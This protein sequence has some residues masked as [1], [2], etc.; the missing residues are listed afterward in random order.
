MFCL[1]K[2]IG[3]CDP[4]RLEILW[5]VQ[6]FLPKNPTQWIP[7]LNNSVVAFDNL[8]VNIVQKWEYWADLLQY[9]LP[10]FHRLIADRYNL[11]TGVFESHHIACSARRVVCCRSDTSRPCKTQGPL[12]CSS[13]YW[14]K[15]P[16]PPYIWKGEVWRALMLKG[17]RYIS[18]ADP[19]LSSTFLVSKP[20]HSAVLLC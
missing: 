14:P 10:V 9:T 7:F 17:H 2:S 20:T 4:C 16:P 12:V 19:H 18:I 5:G 6:F 3:S 11:Y 8:A 13:E 15:Q 1:C